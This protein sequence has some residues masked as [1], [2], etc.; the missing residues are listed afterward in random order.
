MQSSVEQTSTLQS[1][2]Q[3]LHNDEVSKKEKEALSRI[4][5][6]GSLGMHNRSTF[7]ILGFAPVHPT[8]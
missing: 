4:E 7:N 3:K 2:L 8:T 6:H 5:Y 1:R